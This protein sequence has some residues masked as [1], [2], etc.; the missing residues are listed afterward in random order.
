MGAL[1]FAIK[2]TSNQCTDPDNSLN[3]NGKHVSKTEYSL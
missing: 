2:N 1:R 3:S